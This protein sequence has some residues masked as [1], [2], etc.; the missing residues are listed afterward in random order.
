MNSCISSADTS[1][2][3]KFAQTLERVHK[4]RGYR[5]YAT[6]LAPPLEEWP[7]GGRFKHGLL[8]AEGRRCTKRVLE[9]PDCHLESCWQILPL[10][11][12]ISLPRF[13]C[14]SNST[15]TN[16]DT[17][18]MLSLSGDSKLKV[19]LLGLGSNENSMRC[20]TSD[21]FL[22][23][24]RVNPVVLTSLRGDSREVG[25]LL[26]RIPPRSS[27]GTTLWDRWWGTPSPGR[28]SRS[29]SLCSSPTMR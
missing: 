21:A 18:C 25:V 10:S 7:R 15:S 28:R 20:S 4:H 26:G 29:V 5:S 6:H 12:C 11:S 24:L 27:G 2:D 17:K 14:G 19:G 22:A 13:T 1:K 16:N 3:L 8:D 23:S 9:E